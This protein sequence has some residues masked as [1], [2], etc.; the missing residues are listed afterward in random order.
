MG[1]KLAGLR[2]RLGRCSLDDRDELDERR[3][4]LVAQEPVHACAVIAVAVCI[5]VRT[6]QAT[7][8]S[9]PGRLLRRR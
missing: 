9:E 4:K 5:V 8:G 3:F 7:V 2:E 6:F 1:H